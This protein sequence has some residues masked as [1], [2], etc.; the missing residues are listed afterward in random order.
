MRDIG[1]AV[2]FAL[3]NAERAQLRTTAAK[4]LIWRTDGD[5]CANQRN[6]HTGGGF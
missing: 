2:F 4:I 5:T 6:L 1:G 3:I